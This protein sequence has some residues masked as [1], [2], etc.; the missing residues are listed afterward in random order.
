MSSKMSE[1]PP[2]P[3]PPPAPPPAH[4]AIL[5]GGMAEAVIGRALLR[6]LQRLVGLV[7]F[8]ELLLGGGRR[9]CGRDGTASPSLRKA[10]FSSFSSAVLLTPSVS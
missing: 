1:K 8:L 2:A 3:K 9:D 5:E 7:D 10:L 6:V 4:A